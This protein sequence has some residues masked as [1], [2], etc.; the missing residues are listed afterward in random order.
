MR[1]QAAPVSCIA[2]VSWSPVSCPASGASQ[3]MFCV[4]ITSSVCSSGQ[5]NG[6]QGS[7]QAPVL[8]SSDVSHYPDVTCLTADTAA[9]CRTDGHIKYKSVMWSAA[10]S[11]EY[12]NKL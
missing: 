11:S 9:L 5:C 7:G 4:K 1:Y 12:F 8:L 3:I 6:C 2:P 10:K